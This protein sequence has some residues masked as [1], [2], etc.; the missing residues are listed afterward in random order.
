MDLLVQW[1]SEIASG[2]VRVMF[3]MIV[4]C[5]GETLVAMNRVGV[6]N[7]S[8]ARLNPLGNDK[9]S[10]VHSTTSPKALCCANI[11][12]AMAKIRSLV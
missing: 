11:V 5:S 1:R 10:M 3:W 2:Q 8:M 9:L 4:I 7:E 6:S 12:Q